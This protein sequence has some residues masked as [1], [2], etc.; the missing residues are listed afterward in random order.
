M[1]KKNLILKCFVTMENELTLAPD[2]NRRMREDNEKNKLL[3][4]L[5]SH[6][7]NKSTQ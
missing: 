2:E 4:K 7:K 1:R 3:L 6:T 5:P